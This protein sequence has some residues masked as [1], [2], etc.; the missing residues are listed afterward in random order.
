MH[1]TLLSAEG[2]SDPKSRHTR[3][4]SA[5]NLAIFLLRVTRDADL[6]WTD[7]DYAPNMN[8][9]FIWHII[10]RRNAGGRF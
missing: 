8:S 2:V 9:K 5:R 6:F 1:N 4:H 10:L 3:K 7:T